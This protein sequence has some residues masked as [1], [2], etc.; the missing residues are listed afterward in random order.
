M[1]VAM[2]QDRDFVPALGRHELTGAYDRVLAVM[3][4]ERRWRCAL[5]S[6]ADPQPG[7]TILDVGCGTGTFAIQLKTASPGSRL[8]GVDPD[9]AVLEIARDKARR[10]G[11]HVEWRAATGTR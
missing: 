9:K 6:E 2:N 11:V 1:L 10:A 7:E 8:I 5:L 4:R 3:T